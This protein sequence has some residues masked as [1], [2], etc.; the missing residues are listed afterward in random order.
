MRI[1][2]TICYTVSGA[3]SVTSAVIAYELYGSDAALGWAV[4]HVVLAVS[5]MIV[6]WMFRSAELRRYNMYVL[7]FGPAFS[8]VIEL[9]VSAAYAANIAMHMNWHRNNVVGSSS[10]SSSIG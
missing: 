10:V 9:L 3:C 2:N 1:S 8:C 5:L 7:A 6:C 4:S